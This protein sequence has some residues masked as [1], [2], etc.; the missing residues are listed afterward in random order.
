MHKN[1]LIIFSAALICAAGLVSCKEQQ[2][3][4]DTPQ[5]SANTAETTFAAPA[6]DDGRQ[7]FDAEGMHFSAQSGFYE[8]A[9]SLTITA[10]DGAEI[11][12]TLDGSDPTAESLHYTEPITINDRSSEPDVLAKH[13]E[14]TVPAPAPAPKKAVDKATVVKVIAID[15]NGKQSA[16]VTNTYFV[17]FG[18]KSESYQNV[19]I[20]SLI[21]DEQ[22][23]FDPETGIYVA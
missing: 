6:F 19:K 10:K 8:D 4:P 15:G 9:F 3:A 14:I 21:T 5:E 20:I 11:Y 23:L 13:T 2:P 22:N 16:V 12:Y 18:G 7:S 1:K 17:G